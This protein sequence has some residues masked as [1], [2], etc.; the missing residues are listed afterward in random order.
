[1]ELLSSIA[2]TEASKVMAFGAAKYGEDNWRK[3]IASKR[4]LGAALRHTLAYLGGESKDPET[5]L[6]HMAHAMVN[7]MFL[8]E[9]EVT[10]PKLDDRYVPNVSHSE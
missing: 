2:L 8:L 4:L 1:M 5:G 3:G 10:N 7:C 9:F 6:S